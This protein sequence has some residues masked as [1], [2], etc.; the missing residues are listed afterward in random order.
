M[1]KIQN[2]FSYA[3]V[4]ELPTNQIFELFDLSNNGK[5]VS[6]YK[7]DYAVNKDILELKWRKLIAYS[8]SRM[9]Y[10]SV[11][12]YG[13]TYHSYVAREFRNRKETSKGKESWVKL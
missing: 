12:G 2:F 1:K 5:D 11:G 6:P 10:T 9:V 13:V 3:K 7:I 4:S 8:T